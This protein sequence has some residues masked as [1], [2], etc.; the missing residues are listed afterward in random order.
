MGRTGWA[1]PTGLA[2]HYLSVLVNFIGTSSTGLRLHGRGTLRSFAGVDGD[3][4]ALSFN[5]RG[6]ITSCS[7]LSPNS[8]G[9]SSILGI[10]WD[11]ALTSWAFGEWAGSD[12]GL[13]SDRLVGSSL[14]QRLGSINRQLRTSR[15]K[16]ALCIWNWTVPH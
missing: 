1:S 3:G 4:Q 5:R 15:C 10:A 9:P 16:C 11:T 2:D 12:P 7:E 8:A 14:K 13:R 6:W